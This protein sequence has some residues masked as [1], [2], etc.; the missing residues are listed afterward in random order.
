MLTKR[1]FF[2]LL[3]AIFCYLGAAVVEVPALMYISGIVF[4]LLLFCFAWVRLSSFGVGCELKAD[5]QAVV[6][7][8]AL[9]HVVLSNHWPLP[10]CGLLLDVPFPPGDDDEKHLSMWIDVIGAS[11]NTHVEVSPICQVRGRF[12]IGP[13]GLTYSDP[14]GLFTRRRRFGPEQPIEV[15]P[16]YVKLNCFPFLEAGAGV[17]DPQRSMPRPGYSSEFYAIRPYITGDSPR[18]I[19]WLSTMRMQRLMTRQFQSPVQRRTMIV[20]DCTGGGHFKFLARHDAFETAVVT[21]ASVARFA[22]ETDHEVGFIALGMEQPPIKPS[23]GIENLRHIFSLLAEVKQEGKK[24]AEVVAR[25]FSTNVQSLIFITSSPG[26]QLHG[27]LQRMRSN[28]RKVFAIVVEEDKD[29]GS[30][31]AGE[32]INYF[33]SRGIPACHVSARTSIKRDLENPIGV[34]ES[35]KQEGRRT[36]NR[37]ASPTVRTKQRIQTGLTDRW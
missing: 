16:P 20:L 17:R 30:R 12:N 19:H 3:F 7:E 25:R 24:P 23:P 10:R 11:A 8:P 13:V 27:L 15:L 22:S 26:K 34:P 32:C 36:R 6:G 31:R 4:S 28:G 2:F 29:G 9:L 1:S 37:S 33:I 5:H 35:F 21:A 18:W 14:L